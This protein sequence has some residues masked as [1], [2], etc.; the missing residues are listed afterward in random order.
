MASCPYCLEYKQVSRSNWRTW[1][2]PLGVLL[3][4]PFRCMVCDRRFWRF[5]WESI[6]KDLAEKRIRNQ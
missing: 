6:H 4:R 1:E 5:R 2:L 3:I